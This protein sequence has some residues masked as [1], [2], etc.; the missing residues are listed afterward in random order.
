MKPIQELP[1][2]EDDSRN[3]NRGFSRGSNGQSRGGFYSGNRNCDQ[4]SKNL[5]LSFLILR[6][7]IYCFRYLL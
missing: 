3:S 1:E 7:F 6:F 2:L 5:D 4:S